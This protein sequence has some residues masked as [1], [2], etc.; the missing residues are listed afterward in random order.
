MINS[1][2]CLPFALRNLRFLNALLPYTHAQSAS[3]LFGICE[4]RCREPGAFVRASAE[5]TPA[6]HELTNHSRPS[7]GLNA[8]AQTDRGPTSAASGRGTPEN[9]S[10]RKDRRV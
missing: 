4:L 5:A 10:S 8:S 2:P 3:V 6:K 9:H 1:A 7:P